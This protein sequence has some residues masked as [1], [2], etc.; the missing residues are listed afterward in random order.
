[1]LE[2]GVP[3]SEHLVDDEQLR[4][5]RRR[6]GENE[7]HLHPG[8]IGLQRLVD[9]FLEF[10][11]FDDIVDGAV[12][13]LAGLAEIGQIGIGVLPPGQLRM[14]AAANLQQRMRLPTDFKPPRGRL[15]Q[16]GDQLQK[17]AFAGAVAADESDLLPSLDGQRHAVDRH[18]LGEVHPGTAA[19]AENLAHP[20]PR[21]RIERVGLGQILR[22]H[23]NLRHCRL[24]CP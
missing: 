2:V 4:R 15:D 10:G 18:V 11:K 22:A 9:I 20:V 6:R 21:A 12:G 7:P 23:H 24:T 14:K 5:N 13:G 1:M 3:N 17:R 19:E 8:R 16:A